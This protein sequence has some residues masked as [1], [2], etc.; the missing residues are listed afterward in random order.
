MELPFFRILA[1]LLSTA[2]DPLVLSV[3]ASDIGHY[4]KRDPSSKK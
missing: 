1:R 3:A 4:V 2:V